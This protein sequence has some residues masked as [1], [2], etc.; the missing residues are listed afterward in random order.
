MSDASDELR[1]FVTLK[2]KPE[3][4]ATYL[5]AMKDEAAGARSE[6]DNLGFDLFEDAG[7]ARTIYLL[8]HWA[9]KAALEQ[10]HARQPCYIHVRGLEADALTG[11]F[12]E[13]RLQEVEPQSPRLLQSAKTIGGGK[14]RAVILKSADGD[15]F[16]LLEEAFADL[17]SHMR[18]ASGN[19]VFSLFRNLDNANER[20]FFEAWDDNDGRDQGWATA[21]AQR[22]TT[23]LDASS[24]AEK[25]SIVL[26]DRGNDAA[27]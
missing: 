15:A 13:R 12:E 8:E 19:R 22:L 20:L 10:E 27:A 4:L 3:Q 23:L 6:P 9:S 2:V 11:E 24:W 26:I 14:F 17:A 7:D 16:K 25:H 18:N 5:N 1:L 21:A